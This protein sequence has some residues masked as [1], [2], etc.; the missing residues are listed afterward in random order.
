MGEAGL[1]AEK[2]RRTLDLEPRL[3]LDRVGERTQVRRGGHKV[4]R[5]VVVLIERER[6]RRVSGYAGSESDAAK[7]KQR[8][9]RKT[10]VSPSSRH[11]SARTDE[12]AR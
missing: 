6:R 3:R 8:R 11:G 1:R 10:R 7:T 12:V 4:K 2:G 5:V 9:E